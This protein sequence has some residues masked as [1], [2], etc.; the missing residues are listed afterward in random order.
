MMECQRASSSWLGG[1]CQLIQTA[2]MERR[3]ATGD[4]HLTSINSAVFTGGLASPAR[5]TTLSADVTH[6]TPSPRSARRH[7]A[8]NVEYVEYVDCLHVRRGACR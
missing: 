6:A 4:T 5:T 2:S 8:N 3:A 1:S 7:L